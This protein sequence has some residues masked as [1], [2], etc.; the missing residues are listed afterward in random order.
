MIEELDDIAEELADKL[1]IYG[2]ERS[3]WTGEFERRIRRLPLG[4]MAERD[5]YDLGFKHGEERG[6]ERYAQRLENALLELN[7]WKARYDYILKLK[8]EE[9][10][11]QPVQSIILEHHPQ[12]ERSG[13]EEE[14]NGR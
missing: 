4:A 9:L 6:M 7:E 2:E 13:R 12:Q 1:G 3:H 10:N 5:T 11:L 8:V 14:Q